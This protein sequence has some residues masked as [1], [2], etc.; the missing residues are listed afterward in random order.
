MRCCQCVTN[1]CSGHLARAGLAG[2]LDAPLYALSA[3]V[4]GAGRAFDRH[5]HVSIVTWRWTGS[6]SRAPCVLR[7]V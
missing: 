3:L 4:V 7:C 5:L 1:S 2:V 6:F